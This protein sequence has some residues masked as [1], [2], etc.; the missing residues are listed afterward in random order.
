MHLINEFQMSLLLMATTAIGAALLSGRI[1][2]EQPDR[3][4]D[5]LSPTE[6][7]EPP[8]N[9]RAGG[10]WDWLNGSISKVAMRWFLG[11]MVWFLAWW[12]PVSMFGNDSPC[13]I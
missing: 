8:L 10:F 2:A 3:A 9:A 5:R 13:P 6:F 1:V 4:G 11:G 7:V 12:G